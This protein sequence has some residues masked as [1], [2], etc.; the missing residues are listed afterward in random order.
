[1][2][3]RDRMKKIMEE[4]KSPLSQARPLNP[5]TVAQVSPFA[6]LL[7]GNSVK[8]SILSFRI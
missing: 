4:S 1:M 5:T 7:T 2:Q 8:K 6:G 3:Q